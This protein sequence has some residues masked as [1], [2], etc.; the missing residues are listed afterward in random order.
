MGEGTDVVWVDRP[1]V[2][3]ELCNEAEKAGVVAVDTEADSFHSYFPKVCLIQLSFDGR[4]A[5]LDTL[6]LASE[7][8]APLRRL[9]QNPQV[10]KIFHGADYDLRML[11]KD[12]GF[13]V[14]HI[15]DTQ[16]AAQVLG[17]K[18]TSLAALLAREL[19]VNL[20]KTH[21]RAD[22]ALRPLPLAMVEY[23][24]N[25]TR[26][27]EQLHRRLMARLHEVGRVDWWLEECKALE[28]VRYQ[29][30]EPDPLAFR[31]IKG[32]RELKG[33]SLG[34]LASLWRW[35]EEVA[36]RLDVPPFRV[37]SAELLLRLAKEAPSNWAELVTM[38]GLP[39]K[40]IR[41]WGQELLSALQRP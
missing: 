27:L 21:Q 39:R 12:F 14:R 3:P 17:E 26:H 34:R 1:A 30:P 33:E 5:L 31:R 19:G 22:W 13:S 29:A 36:Q 35:R 24:T 4:H 16:A 28:S 25:D 7:D 20:D 32:A 9:L 15:A 40:V 37:L 2:V 38:A 8:L 6:C 10:L 41:R 23:A 18:Q 11:Q